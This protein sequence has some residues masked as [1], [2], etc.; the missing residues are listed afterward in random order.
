[1][2]HAGIIDHYIDIF[3]DL[4]ILDFPVKG[5]ELPLLKRLGEA[6][7]IPP[8]LHAMPLSAVFCRRVSGRVG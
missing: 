4:A 7:E 3:R 2:M 6:G 1:M 8:G 5:D